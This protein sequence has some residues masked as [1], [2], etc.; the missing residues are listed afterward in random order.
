[1]EKES[2]TKIF[3]P[4]FGVICIVLCCYSPIFFNDFLDA[5]DDQWMIFNPF[6]ENGLNMRN[7]SAVFCHSIQ[8]QYSPLVELNYVFLY[9]LFG[10]N[11]FWFHLTSLVWHCACVLLA[12]AFMRRVLIEGG[13]VCQKASQ[14]AMIASFLFAIH[15]V[16]F[17]HY[18]M[19]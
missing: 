9:N 2:K 12:F 7:V 17:V 14:I 16:S 8:G 4:L 3:F 19:V 10:Y 18:L 11:P 13:V 15:P 5:W 6:T 1:M